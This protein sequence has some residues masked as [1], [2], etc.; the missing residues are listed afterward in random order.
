MTEDV[1]VHGN[2]VSLLSYLAQ[3]QTGLSKVST[4]RGKYD[5]PVLFNFLCIL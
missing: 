4:G 3:W 5:H 1:H 2:N